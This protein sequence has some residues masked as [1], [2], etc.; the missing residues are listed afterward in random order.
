MKIADMLL[1]YINQDYLLPSIQREFV[2]LENRSE[3]KV[4]KLF[5]SILQDYPIGTILVWQVDKKEN[6]EKQ[7]L[8]VY[9]FV[10]EYDDEHPRN[11]IASTKGYKRIYLVL[12]GQQRLSALNI[13]LRGAFLYS[14]YKK[15]KRER[16]FLNL[17]YNDEADQD[18]I[19]GFKYEFKFFE[20]PPEDHDLYWFEVGLVLDYRERNAEDFKEDFDATIR[21]RTSDPDKMKKAKM[22]LGR[23]HESICSNDVLTI[24]YFPTD[25]D[26]KA[27]N[28]FVRTNDGGV[29]LEKA[30]LLLSYMESNKQIFQP[31]GARQEV[32]DFVDA[33]NKE[34]LGKPNYVFAKDDVL[35]ASLVLSDLPVRYRLKN[36]NGENLHCISDKWA[37]VKKYLQL[38]VK[39]IARYGFSSLNI[40]S[41]NSLIPIAYYLKHA[42]RSADFIA[43][44]ALEDIVVK[45]DIINWLVISQLTGAFGSSSDTTLQSVRAAIEAGK[46]FKD[47]NL[48][49]S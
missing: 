9:E 35:K 14:H 30:D 5:D 18:N 23:L 42:S 47:I 34:E 38:T 10:R 27:L 17:L 31:K 36:F 3:H 41:K 21:E 25:D 48:G 28:V 12:D 45:N 16:L 39:L 15:Q 32:F 40:M 29:K 2:W 49:P 13:G 33:L 4:E 43:S 20:E 19:Y 44:Q 11:K 37:D 8:E 26:E 6:S 46:T 22:V 1:R 24:K 7:D